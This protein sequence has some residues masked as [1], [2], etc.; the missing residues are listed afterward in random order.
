MISR[1]FT[2]RLAPTADQD[3]TFRRFAGVC[4]A[5]YNAAL[6]QRAQFWRQYQRA[7]GETLNY[8]AQARELTDLRA[9]FEWV[10]AVSQTC[11][12]QALRDLEK[13]FA[14]FFA[15]RAQY[16][17]PR[18]KGEHESFRFQG[19]E[20]AIERLNRNWS[21]V[22][23]PKIGWVRFRDTRPLAGTI[24][25]ATVRLTPLGWQ[26]AFACEIEHSAPCNFGPGVGIDRG[27]ANSIALSTGELASVPVARLRALDRKHRKAQQAAAR[28]HR[29]SGRYAKA[30]KRAAAIKAKAARLRKDWNH[31]ATAGIAARYGVVVIE[32]LQTRNMTASARGTLD[33]PGRQV[34]QKAGLNRAIL[35]QGWQQFETFLAYKLAAAGG[36]L[37]KVDPRNT[38]RTCHHCGTVDALSRESQAHFKCVDCGH[39]AHADVN[40]ARNI[41]T[42]G[43]RPAAEV[44][45]RRESRRAA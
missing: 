11:Q 32:A 45:S 20:V 14:N 35:E 40:A 44:A 23:L 31:K 17:T 4:R 2:F 28:R 7:T 29:G 13:A 41:L 38:S 10:A 34:R 39:Q 19:R 37:V 3:V 30:R 25:N 5:V 26:I 15:G 43:T 1:G 18:R 33:Q 22:R 36:R 21:R 9:E 8:G 24:K 27:V 42:A 12:Q 6:S 16:P